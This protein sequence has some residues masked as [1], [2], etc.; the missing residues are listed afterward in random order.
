MFES[1]GKPREA[2]KS[3]ATSAAWVSTLTVK[4]EVPLSIF[5]SLLA[6]LVLSVEMLFAFV[7]IWLCKLVSALDR[8]V[9][10]VEILFAFVVIWF[11][12]VVSAVVLF[13]V[14]VLTAVV[15]VLSAVSRPCM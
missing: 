10:S 12:K 13:V 15:R 11:C 3:F 4:G 14:S 2:S 8:E 6:R 1:L 7:V 9:L 5:V